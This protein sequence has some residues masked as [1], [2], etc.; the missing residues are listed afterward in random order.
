MSYP[1]DILKL[2]KNLNRDLVALGV[3]KIETSSEVVLYDEVVTNKTL[4]K[5]TEKLFK[6]GHH[7]R[8]VEEAYKLLN[9]VDA[10]LS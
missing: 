9:N 10:R 5:K 8:A 2:A 1:S 6:D 4:I 3:S 7:A